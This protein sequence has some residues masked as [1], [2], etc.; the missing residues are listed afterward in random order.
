MRFA[1]AVIAGGMVQV[2]PYLRSGIPTVLAIGYLVFA[3][4]GVGFFA[5]RRTWLAGALSVFLGALFFG[6]WERASGGG[7]SF[8]E[9][10]TAETGLVLAVIP[11]AILGA[12][13]G[14]AGGWLRSRI[15]PRAR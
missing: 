13:A 7:I 5:V 14:L 15:V 8:G 1:A 4:L 12:L 3:A 9:L 11:Y 2:V 6:V 10:V